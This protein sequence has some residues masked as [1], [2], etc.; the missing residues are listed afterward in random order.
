M[1]TTLTSEQQ[2]TL[3]VKPLTA[4]GKAAIVD[5]APFWSS[6]NVNVAT[7]VVAPD[8]LSVVVSAVGAG[9]STITVAADADLTSG[10]NQ[11]STSIDAVVTQAPAASLSFTVGT[12]VDAP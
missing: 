2:V 3:T 5:G 8:G 11:I 6:S 12:P 9:T 1:Q 4:K 7:L 10:V